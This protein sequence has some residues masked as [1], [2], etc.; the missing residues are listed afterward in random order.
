[1]QSISC[2][3]LCT[4]CLVYDWIKMESENM[5]EFLHQLDRGHLFKFQNLCLYFT[6][7]FKK[8]LLYQSTVSCKI[9]TSWGFSTELWGCQTGTQQPDAAQDGWSWILGAASV[10]G[11]FVEIEGL[12]RKNKAKEE[13]RER[14][15]K[16]SQIGRQMLV[17]LTGTV[18]Q[19]PLP[20]AKPVFKI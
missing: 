13:E 1:M 3:H 10:R 18:T 11:Y 9:S 7:S 17:I 14:E 4:S 20:N 6:W 16:N 12:K 15:E 8:L 19:I 5:Y 2:A